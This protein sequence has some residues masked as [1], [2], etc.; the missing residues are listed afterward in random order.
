LVPAPQQGWRRLPTEW[1]LDR[2]ERVARN[3]DQQAA[4]T[5]LAYHTLIRAARR[6]LES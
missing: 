1:Q 6:K 2:R 5:G 3:L 4:K